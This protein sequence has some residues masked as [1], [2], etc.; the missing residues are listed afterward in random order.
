MA[1]LYTVKVA[2]NSYKS[3]SKEK[4][5][6]RKQCPVLVDAGVASEVETEGELWSN[7]Y[8]P[9]KSCSLPIAGKRAHDVIQ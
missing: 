1:T 9:P 2:N 7:L 6:E 8:L 5:K 3:R 4:E